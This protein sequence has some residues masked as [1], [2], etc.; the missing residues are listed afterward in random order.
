MNDM[1]QLKRKERRGAVI[2]IV[3]VC[4]VLAGAMFVSLAR[5]AAVRR[6]ADRRRQWAVQAR[7]LAEAGLERAVARLRS[8]PA[9][10][11]ERWTVAE[12]E[13]SGRAGAAVRIVVAA[14]GR[15]RRIKAVADFPDVPRR[16]CRCTRETVIEL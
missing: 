3:M 5:T 2:V 6:Q 8:D 1:R 10:S 11:G 7:W 14:E 4:F 16:R 15:R 9:Y 13:L 12:E